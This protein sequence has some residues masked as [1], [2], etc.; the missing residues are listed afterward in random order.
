[1]GRILDYA[2]D[3]GGR[4]PSAPPDFSSHLAIVLAA[5]ARDG[6]GV[7]WT[8]LSLVKEDLEQGR[9]VRAG[10]EAEDIEMEIRLWRPRARQ[11]PAAEAL[12]SRILA[13]QKAD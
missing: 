6:R 4:E 9:L 1:M 8:A 11:S 5:M 10:P 13:S 7:A 3:R 12:W 2:W